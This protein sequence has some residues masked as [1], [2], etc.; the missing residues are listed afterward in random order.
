MCPH[1][2]QFYH[3]NT[4]PDRMRPVRPNHPGQRKS[5]LRRQRPSETSLPPV[6]DVGPTSAATS[7]VG[8]A[9][10]LQ[11]R[12]AEPVLGHGAAIFGLH[13]EPEAS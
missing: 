13:I 1:T 4:M 5:T 2:V 3:A 7:R 9:T 10:R 12:L 6:S 11:G 8:R